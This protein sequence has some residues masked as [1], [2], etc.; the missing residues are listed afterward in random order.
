MIGGTQI[1]AV[2]D[3]RETD[4]CLERGPEFVDQLAKG[5]LVERFFIFDM[6]NILDRFRRANAD[7]AIASEAPVGRLERRYPAELPLA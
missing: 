2:D 7:A 4:D 6:V 3:L 5:V 1:L